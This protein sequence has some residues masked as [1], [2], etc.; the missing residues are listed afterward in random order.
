MLQNLRV[1]EMFSYQDSI[2]RKMAKGGKWP[3]LGRLVKTRRGKSL[4]NRLW[5][6]QEVVWILLMV[7]ENSEEFRLGRSQFLC[8]IAWVS[9]RLSSHS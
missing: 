5:V 2:D 7:T 8:D 4:G 1:S 9:I 6:L 3:N